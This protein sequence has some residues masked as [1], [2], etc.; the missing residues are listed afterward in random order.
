MDELLLR[1]SESQTEA[2]DYS[3]AMRTLEGLRS[4]KRTD[5][6]VRNLA[7]IRLGVL[8]FAARDPDA[9]DLLNQGW[10]D[11]VKTSG[12]ESIPAAFARIEIAKVLLEIGDLE[13]GES[14]VR[15]AIPVLDGW[16]D[17]LASALCRDVLGRTLQLQGEYAAARAYFEEALSIVE[18]AAGPEHRVYTAALS[19]LGTVCFAQGDYVAAERYTA[20]AF[21]IVTRVFGDAHPAA[22]V[23]RSNLISL[24]TE[25]GDAEGAERLLTRMRELVAT[26]AGPPAALGYALFHQ[27]KLLAARGDLDG[28]VAQCRAAE[29]L[30]RYT[31]DAELPT[32]QLAGYELRRGDAREAELHYEKL[33]ARHRE[34]GTQRTG[35]YGRVLYGLA[36]VALM[37]RR[38]QAAIERADAAISVLETSL[39]PQ[40]VEIAEGLFLKACAY[41]GNAQFDEAAEHLRMASHVEDRY[42][43]PLLS[44]LSTQRQGA[45]LARFRR[46]VDVA[47]SVHLD[48][49]PSNQAC[50]RVAFDIVIQRKNLSGEAAAQRVAALFRTSSDS[51]E[52]RSLQRLRQINQTLSSSLLRSEDSRDASLAADAISRLMEERE[53]I[54]SSL[55]PLVSYTASAKKGMDVAALLETVGPGRLYVD[56]ILYHP[57]D[58]VRGGPAESDESA[59]YA[60][61]WLD[62]DG[63]FGAVPIG[64]LDVVTDVVHRF[65]EALQQPDLGE[66]WAAAQDAY[67]VLLQPLGTRVLKAEHLYVSP[68]ALLQFIPFSALSPG[69]NVTLLDTTSVTYA[70]SA[71]DVIA[72]AQDRTPAR[73]GPVVVALPDFDADFPDHEQTGADDLPSEDQAL[74]V[75]EPVLGGEDELTVLRTLLPNARFWTGASASKATLMAE[76]HGP[77]VFHVATH[78]AVRSRG[79][80]RDA[81]MAQSYLALAGFNHPAYGVSDGTLSGLEASLLDLHGCELATLSACQSGLGKPDV[82]QGV[83]GLRR[84]MQIAGAH[85]VLM[86]LWLVDGEATA[87]LMAA[88]YGNLT[89]GAPRE[90][91]LREAQLRFAERNLHPYTWSGFVLSG[92]TGPV[93][94]QA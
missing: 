40:Y 26:G 1:R 45:L 63:G 28:A 10:S 31:S 67:R 55:P 39:G 18:S 3:K 68:D 86:S 11:T 49:A 60:A 37:R 34:R 43:M 89:R 57:L 15:A 56:Y 82:G 88:F 48:R 74:D 77:I 59:Q 17:R 4:G 20:R 80:T 5:P 90:R 30:L 41:A 72:A 27:A 91:A 6:V 54:E 69:P 53:S 7:T 84:A 70:D 24:R 25:T 8:R 35:E 76:V 87:A 2:G 71:R 73:D 94:A 46:L 65:R 50:L 85:S 36:H 14:F 92:A 29:P 32:E 13:E 19:N 23:A 79:A 93:F 61:Y 66:Y 42:H 38:W 52:R 22:I 21:S 33:A 78:G 47:V 58:P 12:P 62:A 16:N 75:L 51:E 9:L 83:L 64:S 81:A 44:V